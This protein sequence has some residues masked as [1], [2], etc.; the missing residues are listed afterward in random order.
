MLRAAVAVALGLAVVALAVVAFAAVAFAAVV[1]DAVAFAVVRPAVVD[2]A[3][4]LFAAPALAVVAFAFAAAVVFA[5]VVL[6]GAFAVVRFVAAPLAVVGLAFAAAVVFAAVARPVVGFFAAVLL[7][8]ARFGADADLA[9]VDFERAELAAGFF[10]GVALFDA[11]AAV[12]ASDPSVVDGARRLLRLVGRPA[13]RF[14][15]TSL[16]SA[17]AMRRFLHA[18]TRTPD[19]D[20]RHTTAPTGQA[21]RVSDRYSEQSAAALWQITCGSRPDMG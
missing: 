16:L 19:R 1:L 15:R 13:G 7:A 5:R 20:A 11:L 10:A 21:S 6:A 2:L 18:G 8:A 17:S 4:V 9:A 14:A 12:A 3:A